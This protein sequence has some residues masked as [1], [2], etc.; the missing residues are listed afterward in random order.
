VVSASPEELRRYERAERRRIAIL[1]GGSVIIVVAVAVLIALLVQRHQSKVR[2]GTVSDWVSGL[3]TAAGVVVALGVALRE[4]RRTRH[5]EQ[6][7]AWEP[8]SAEASAVSVNAVSL[9]TAWTPGSYL[10]QVRVVVINGSG[11]PIFA[12]RAGP[13][14]P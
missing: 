8:R 4:I 6:Q 11:L 2:W 13:D 1:V 10:A 12:S 7:R 9:G 5:A 14:P 3:I